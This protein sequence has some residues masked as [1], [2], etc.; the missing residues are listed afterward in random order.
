MTNGGQSGG[1][2]QMIQ[3]TLSTRQHGGNG[4]SRLSGVVR[5]AVLGGLLTCGRAM[6]AA[7]AGSCACVTC[8][9]SMASATYAPGAH[10]GITDEFGISEIVGTLSVSLFVAGLGSGPRKC[11]FTRCLHDPLD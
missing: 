7:L 2:E 10:Y 8:C 9:S 5:I 4:P 3:E 11:L 6:T 1:M